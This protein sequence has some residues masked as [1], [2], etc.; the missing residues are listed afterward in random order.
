M[1]RMGP[2]LND[3]YT[4]GGGGL[5][6]CRH[7]KGG[8]VDLVFWILPKCRQGGEGVQ[9]PENYVDVIKYGPQGVFHEVRTQE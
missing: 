5:T 7:S 6:K 9:N 2:Y 1:Q 4:E 3:V 8:C